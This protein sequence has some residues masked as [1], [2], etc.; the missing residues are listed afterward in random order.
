MQS[1]N[2]WIRQLYP[3]ESHGQFE[4][5]RILSFILIPMLVGTIIGNI[6]IKTGAGSIV[7]EFG[8]TE[9]IPTESLF[10]WAALLLIPVFIPLYFASKLY[11]KRVK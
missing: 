5:I 11:Y 9:N 2:M 6:I 10:K 1:M 7:N 8:F 3:E 4:G